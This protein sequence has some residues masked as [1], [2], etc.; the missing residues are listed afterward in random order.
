MSIK[1]SSTGRVPRDQKPH[2]KTM[3]YIQK[4]IQIHGDTYDYS[5]VEFRDTATKI[6]I[7]CKVHGVFLQRPDT[8]LKG[9]G[10]PKCSGKHKKSTKECIQEFNKIHGS[11]Y[12]YSLV[13]YTNTYTK[14]KIICKVHGVFEQTPDNHLRA[15]G[16]PKCGK[17]NQNTLYVLKCTNTGLHKIGITNNLGKR[18]SSIG[19]N[20]EHIYHITTENPRDLEKYL[21][22]RYQNYSV[23]NPH[24]NNGGT[25]FFQLSEPQVEELLCFLSQHQ[26]Q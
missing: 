20:L 21:H 12:D 11:T 22:Q 3:L 14:V 4:F 7:I 8:H 5:Q 26:D 18:M 9:S 16:C 2:I 13:Y 10:C 17:H 19:G 1:L 15:H 24:V 6:R 23:F 25:E